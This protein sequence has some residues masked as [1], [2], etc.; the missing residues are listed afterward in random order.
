MDEQ[1]RGFP[2][3]DAV[4]KLCQ[5]C[6]LCCDGTLF[7]YVTVSAAEAEALRARDVA[8]SARKDGSFRLIQRCRGLEGRGCSIYAERPAPCRAYACLLA[9]ALEEG[10][11]PLPEAMQIVEGAHQKLEKVSE[12]L[13]GEPGQSPVPAVR[14]SIHGDA[15]A[16]TD[17]ASQLWLDARE[18]LRRHFT[19][20]HGLS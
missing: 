19:C 17:E 7:T 14:A 18:Y 15:P 13:G 11:L 6:A 16:L 9:K 4:S 8:L 1:P 2:L 3:S 5:A 20:R 10:E 12:A